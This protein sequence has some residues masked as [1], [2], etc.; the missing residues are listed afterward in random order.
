MPHTAR[1]GEHLR[2]VLE[3]TLR[4]HGTVRTMLFA[5]DSTSA[6]SPAPIAFRSLDADVDAAHAQGIDARQVAIDQVQ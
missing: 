3:L 1:D 2:Y 6:S 4:S 5:S